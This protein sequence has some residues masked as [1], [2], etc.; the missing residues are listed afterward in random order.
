MQHCVTAAWVLY[1]IKINQCRYGHVWWQLEIC[2]DAA[3]CVDGT[4][5]QSITLCL[6][7]CLRYIM[8][9]VSI[10]LALL[11]LPC[12]QCSLAR[13]CQCGDVR[14]HPDDVNVVVIS[15]NDYL[16][17]TKCFICTCASALLCGWNHAHFRSW[18]VIEVRC[19][20]RFGS[21]YKNQFF[22]IF[23]STWIYKVNPPGFH[24]K[25]S[26]KGS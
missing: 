14:M 21:S 18:A 17:E 16:F 3:A 22:F 12:W 19:D 13:H 9:H 20:E 10:S 7:D 8:M 2:H 25:F 4:R 23:F 1:S 5:T 11:G 24:A 26:Q 15:T 6:L